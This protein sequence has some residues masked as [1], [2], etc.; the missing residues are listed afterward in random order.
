MIQTLKQ[1]T[2][3]FVP[4]KIILCKE[5]T[6]KNSICLILKT[7]LRKCAERP[8]D[9]R[10]CCCNLKIFSCNLRQQWVRGMVDPPP[11]Q[12]A[13]RFERTVFEENVSKGECHGQADHV[14]T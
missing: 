10:R 7:T 1:Q 4:Q 8:F 2:F 9:R 3:K 14:K 13:V 5:K 11:F 12:R 6:L